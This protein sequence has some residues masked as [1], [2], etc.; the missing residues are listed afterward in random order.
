[1][2]VLDKWT[3]FLTRG[4]SRRAC[5]SNRYL[6]NLVNSHHDTVRVVVVHDSSR[7]LATMT[8]TKIDS[9]PA[10]ARRWPWARERAAAEYDEVTAHELRASTDSA[11]V[12]TATD[13]SDGRCTRTGARSAR[14]G[15]R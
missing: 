7:N 10:V 14:R 2:A 3:I 12:T 11:V 1:M 13:P 6:G 9:E 15:T 5:F 8:S 4:E